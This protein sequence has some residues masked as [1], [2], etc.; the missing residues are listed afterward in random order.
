MTTWHTSPGAAAPT[1]LF[2]EAIEAT[3]GRL[4][5]KVFMGRWGIMSQ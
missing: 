5:L 1:I 4:G 2:T 3:W